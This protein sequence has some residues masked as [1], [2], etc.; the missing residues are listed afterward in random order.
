MKFQRDYVRVIVA[1]I[2]GPAITIFCVW[3]IRAA[4]I[5]AFSS[6]DVARAAR[7]TKQMTPDIERRNQEVNELTQP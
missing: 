1:C 5:S 2:A 3:L 4:A 6:S 7:L